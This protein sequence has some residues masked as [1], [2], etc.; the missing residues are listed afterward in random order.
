MGCTGLTIAGGVLEVTGFGLVAC[1]LAR[2][3]HREFG[4]PR[5]VSKLRAQAR[6]LLRR[7]VTHTAEGSG[8]ITA[9]GSLHAQGI[10][11]QGSG[12]TLDERVAALEANLG[13]FER[14]VDERHRDVEGRVADVRS[15]LDELQAELAQDRREAEDERRDTLRASVAV[16]AWGTFLFVVGAVLSVVGNTVNC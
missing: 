10:A 7:S 2:V 11:R 1:E 3:Q 15:G 14:E 5:F 8:T 16:Q 13:T 12:D 4:A 9:T 6:R